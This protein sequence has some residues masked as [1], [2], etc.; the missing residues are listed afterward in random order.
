MY[1]IYQIMFG[2]TLDSIAKRFNTTVDKL[3]EINSRINMENGAYI[4]V[5]AFSD[6]AFEMYVVKNGDTLYGIA[7]EYNIDVNDLVALNGLNKTDYLYPNQEIMVPTGK[8]SIYIT[9][10]GD[11]IDKVLINFNTAYDE[12]KR[13]NKNLYLAPDQIITF[14]DNIKM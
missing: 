14:R 3:R 8:A 2:D 5:P 11:T 6:D 13:Q 12:L 4:V 10:Q 9:K 7:R 1:S